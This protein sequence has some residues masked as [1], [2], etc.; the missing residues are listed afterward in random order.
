MAVT[1]LGLRDLIRQRLADERM[2]A[3][4]AGAFGAMA[5]LLVTIGV[6]GLI[7][8]LAVSRTAEIG[9]RLA[10]GATR[11]EIVQLMM[12]ETASMVGLGLVIGVPLAIGSMRAG[13]ALLFGLGAADVPM[14]SGAVLTLVAA[15]ALA[16]LIPAW[17]ACRQDPTLVLRGD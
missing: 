4:L 9:I 5:L 8:Y 6:H 16:G 11:S 10:L 7:A 15:A 17:R 2:T 12:R 13:K 3:W 1:T 14:L